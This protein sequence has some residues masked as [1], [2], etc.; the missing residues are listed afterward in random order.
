MVIRHSW[1]IIFLRRISH[2]FY[3]FVH[4][5][6]IAYMWCRPHLFWKASTL[7]VQT[8][9]YSGRINSSPSGQNGR[10]FVNDILRCIFVNKNYCILIKFHWNLFLR[11]KLTITLNY[12]NQYCPDSRTHTWDVWI[13]ISNDIIT[14]V[15]CLV[16]KFQYSEGYQTV[17]SE[18]EKYSY[19]IN[20]KI[21]DIHPIF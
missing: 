12:L 18:P 6:V 15:T 2:D 20:V 3:V 13:Y 7:L 21:L 5:N 4:W 1:N 10:H 17:M 9:L 19:L 14:C 16:Y 8:L 11:V